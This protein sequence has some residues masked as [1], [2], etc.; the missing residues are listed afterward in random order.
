MLNSPLMYLRILHKLLGVLAYHYV[1]AS[2]RTQVFTNDRLKTSKC[3]TTQFKIFKQIPF[4]TS[5]SF[6]RTVNSSTDQ[7]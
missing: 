6:F 2:T 4:I 7:V 5:T 3:I 1:A